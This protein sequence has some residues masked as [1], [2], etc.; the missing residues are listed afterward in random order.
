MAAFRRQP[1]ASA[2]AARPLASM[3]LMLA[4]YALFAL[5]D[6]SAKYLG[7]W[8][9]IGTITFG[10][11]LSGSV[12]A[13]LAGRLLLGGR[14][15]RTAHPR[16]QILRGVFLLGATFFNFMAVR[17]LQLAQSVAILFSAPLMVCMISPF[18]L[19][20]RV[21][22]RRWAAV[23]VG[24][25][26]VL[27]VIRP[28]TETFHP[29]MFLSLAAAFTLASYQVLTRKV[30]ARD[31]PYASMIWATLTG[32][33][34]SVSLLPVAAEVPSPEWWPWLAFLG[35]AGTAGHL[36][37]TEA[38]R[39]ADASFLAPFAYTQM[40]WMVLIGWWWFGDVPDALTIIGA[41]IVAAA[42][43]F[44]FQR[45]YRQMRKRAQA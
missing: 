13:L 43:L 21:G 3:L 44:V 7:Q 31:N 16:L 33:A 25:A 9:S 37:L 17:Y 38:H 2:T 1:A 26:G 19:G 12:F 27:L 22:W 4:T 14:F 32:L 5:L 39:R 15:W 20:E 28:G 30:G 18:A 29:A 11:Y 36:M 41:L 34:L 45:E 23:I 6:S 8:L 42:S 40:I 10:R 24:F 35:L